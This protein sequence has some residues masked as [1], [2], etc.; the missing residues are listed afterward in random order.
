MSQYFMYDLPIFFFFFFGNI[1]YASMPLSKRFIVYNPLVTF[2]N[3]HG[4]LQ[5]YF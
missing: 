1:S 3:A 5:D 4:K 2:Y